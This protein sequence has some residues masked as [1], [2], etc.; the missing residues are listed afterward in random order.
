[1]AMTE[2][3]RKERILNRHNMKVF[4]FKKKGITYK[5]TVYKSEVNKN[6]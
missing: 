1:M 3:C 4:R 5:Q 2:E 6:S